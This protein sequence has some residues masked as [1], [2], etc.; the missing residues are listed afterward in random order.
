[1][2]YKV[3]YQ[4]HVTVA[5]YREGKLTLGREEW[6]SK[7]GRTTVCFGA[8]LQAP[9]RDPLRW[10]RTLPFSRQQNVFPHLTPT[11]DPRSLPPSASGLPQKEKKLGLSN[12]LTASK[13]TRR[14]LNPECRKTN[15]NLPRLP[16]GAERRRAIPAGPTGCRALAPAPTEAL[17]SPPAQA[18]GLTSSGGSVNL[19][20]VGWPARSSLRGRREAGDERTAPPDGEA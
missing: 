15:G 13:R 2:Q 16:R 6:E 11:R 8:S 18:G 4:K 1:M 19:P 17:P 12:E 7:V 3:G 10:L 20:A 14:H 9:P 5:P